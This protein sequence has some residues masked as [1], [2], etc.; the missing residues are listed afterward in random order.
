MNK[1]NQESWEEIVRTA[2]LLRVSEPT[3]KSMEAGAAGVLPPEKVELP[4]HY[5]SDAMILTELILSLEA[6]GPKISGP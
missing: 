6:R 5:V 4:V 3:L 2:H 1:T